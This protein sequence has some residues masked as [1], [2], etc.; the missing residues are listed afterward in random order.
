[1]QTNDLVKGISQKFEQSR[2]VFWH[3]VDQHFTEE[4]P[5]ILSD[6]GMPSGVK[7]IHVDQESLLATKRRVELN[8]PNCPFLLYFTTSE[9][10]PELDWLL[11]IRLYSEHFYA[12]RSSMLL[13]ELGIGTMSL[14]SHIHQ[15]QSFFANKQRL[16]AL[17]KWVVEEENEQSL[18]RKMI[19]VV[20]RSDS[21]SVTDI[22]FSLLREY[23]GQI[24]ELEHEKSFDQALDLSPMFKQLLK[25]DLLNSFWSLMEESFGYKNSEEQPSFEVFIRTLLCTDLWS[26]IVK[27]DRSWLQNNILSTPSGRST[28]LAFLSSWRDSR[29]YSD[30]YEIIAEHFSKQL[31]VKANIQGYS[32]FALEECETFADIEQVV[33]KG[34]VYGVIDRSESLDPTVFERILSRRLAGHWTHATT[35]KGNFYAS[36]YQGLRNAQILF[37]LRE[38]FVDGFHYESALSLYKAYEEELYRFDQAYRLFNEHVYSVQSKGAD[39]LRELD[40]A[41]EDLYSNWYL[42]ELGLAWDRLLDKE[43]RLEQWQLPSI[44]NQY[45]FYKNEV[46]SRLEDTQVKRIFVVISDALRYEIAH[47]LKDIIDSEK[48]FKASLGSQLGVL[49]SYTQLGMA[50]LLPHKTVHYDQS[51]RSGEGSDSMSPTKST[52]YVDDL[53][54]QG[55]LA[56][57]S[58]LERY[59]G[60]A[61]SAKDLMSWSNQEGREQVKDAQVV[62]IYHDTI[63]AIGDVAKTEEKTFEACRDAINELKDLVA[64]II[65]RLNASQVLIT[66]D[67]GFLF[68]QQAMEQTNRTK[69]QSSQFNTM[70]A[71]KRYIIGSD[72]PSDESYWK[73]NISNTAQ[74]VK[75]LAKNS[76]FLLPK[77]VQRFH[78]VGGARFVH[79]GAMPQEICVP[80]L[81]VRELQKHQAAQHEKQPVGVVVA[82]QPIKLVNNIDKVQFIQTDAVGGQFVPRQ[83][84]LV[85]V[86]PSGNEVSSRETVL[87]DSQGKTI[88][89]RKR[90]ARFKLIG[91]A[92]NRN[93]SYKLI[94]EN[95]STKTRYNEYSVTIDLAI[96]D[97]FF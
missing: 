92:F 51:A 2:I 6:T 53:P 15:R 40:Q 47:E 52:V 24:S 71:K 74:Q 7:V 19:A 62:Y 96:Q 36:I 33:I 54:T 20:A 38:R 10:K 59:K 69:L 95:T 49:P 75:E 34:L 26:H 85:I 48:R 65:N 50:A 45:Q 78:F 25:Y 17:H 58:V 87:F 63:D 61:V 8:E 41:V 3:D 79:G 81:H 72:L 84:E 13:A 82:T 39:I 88:D 35:D 97:D 5:L 30:F 43:N 42:Y 83:L 68:Q 12:D 76:E 57:N 56:R 90:E 67:H 18:D 70:E 14:R 37:S 60:M 66:A 16:A 91:S 46:Q 86:D 28:A 80:I 93:T 9:P 73:G 11:D 94:L 29:T 31:E 77:G 55:L 4:L 21:S 89:E 1:M 32:V 22:L 44:P 23:A 27:E 64:R